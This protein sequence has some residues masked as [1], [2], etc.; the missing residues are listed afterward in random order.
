METLNQLT[1]DLELVNSKI[2]ACSS[3]NDTKDLIQKREDLGVKISTLQPQL[4]LMMYDMYVAYNSFNDTKD[5]I[6]E[7]EDLEVITFMVQQ[8]RLMIDKM[9]TGNKL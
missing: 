6:Q 3:F 8:E 9:L 2:K 7:Q 4:Q 1:A 5:L